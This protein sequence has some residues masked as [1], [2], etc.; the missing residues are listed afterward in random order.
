MIRIAIIIGANATALVVADQV[1]SLEA[2]GV[3][4]II[5]IIARYI[6]AVCATLGLSAK[7]TTE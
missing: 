6:I 5:F 7:I 4:S 3:P 1:F 2:G